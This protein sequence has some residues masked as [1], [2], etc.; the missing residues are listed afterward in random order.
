MP[1]NF[2]KMNKHDSDLSNPNPLQQ[3]KKLRSNYGES[4]GEF[5]FVSNLK[6]KTNLLSMSDVKVFGEF[7]LYQAKDE[8]RTFFLKIIILVQMMKP[9]VDPA[10]DY[11]YERELLGICYYI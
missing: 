2:L 1:S 9:L 5:E 10:L 7:F 8:G 6:P 3:I 4:P 11:E